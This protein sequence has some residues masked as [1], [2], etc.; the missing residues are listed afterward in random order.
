MKKGLSV[1]NTPCRYP[2]RNV[3]LDQEVREFLS[4]YS[5]A[6]PGWKDKKSVFTAAK[7][8]ES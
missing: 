2:T 8:I 3:Y 1:V 4:Y 7:K 6:C 5:F